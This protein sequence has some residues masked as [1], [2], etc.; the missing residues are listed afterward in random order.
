MS[1]LSGGIFLGPA[2]GQLSFPLGYLQ[3][4]SHWRGAVGVDQIGSHTTL[5][6]VS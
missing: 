2:K 5:G 1:I 3:A 6:G 4:L